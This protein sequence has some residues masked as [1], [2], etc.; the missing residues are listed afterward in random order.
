MQAQAPQVVG[1]APIMD[2]TMAQTMQ[3]SMPQQI[4]GQMAATIPIT[5]PMAAGIPQPLTADMM[6]AAMQQAEQ[7]KAMPP[8]A[9]ISYDTAPKDS[10]Q[11]QGPLAGRKHS[12][13]RRPLRFW[14]PFNEWWRSELDRMGRRP[15]AQEIAD[16]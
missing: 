13:D 9:P 8:V 2:H 10:S 3:L 11:G 16:W 1:T 12:A 14:Q 6:E 7:E 4:A 5:A 15:T